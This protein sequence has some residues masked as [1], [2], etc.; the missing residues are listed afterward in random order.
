MK[1]SLFGFDK[2]LEIEKGG[3]GVLNVNNPKLFRSLIDILSDKENYK[4]TNDIIIKEDDIIEFE[5]IKFVPNVLSFDFD[6]K[7]VLQ[8]LIVGYMAY[9]NY[10]EDKFQQL[11]STSKELYLDFTNYLQIEEI[12]YSGH[13]V[14][15]ASI[16]KG[17]DFSFSIDNSDLISKIEQV[18]NINYKLYRIQLF[19]FM[20]LHQ[21]MTNEEINLICKMAQKYNV[22]IM[23]LE[24][25]EDCNFSIKSLNITKDFGIY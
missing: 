18:I 22:Y 5:R 8:K 24:S 23:Y 2:Y 3:C 17:F 16:L 9:I 21:I 20:N 1:I 11:Y 6:T 25:R 15:L 10:D 13:D 7:K 12:E 14:Q 19:V 4:E